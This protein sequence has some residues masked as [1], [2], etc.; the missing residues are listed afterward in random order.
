M[1]A[2]SGPASA[3]KK[4]TEMQ[5]KDSASRCDSGSRRNK[6]GSMLVLTLLLGGL[7]IFICIVAFCFFLLLS[8]NKKGRAKA[9]ETAV[10]FAKILNEDDRVGQLNH[11]VAR[12][13]ELVYLSR[14]CEQQAA[15]AKLEN[16][17]PLAHFLLDESRSG[18]VL[19][20]GERK[21]QIEVSKKAL[22]YAADHYNVH[23]VDVP[24]FKLPFWHTWDAEVS[25]IQLG[26]AADVESNVLN[27]ET[28]PDL[29]AYDEHEK[30][31]QKGSDLYRGNINARLPAP[32]N[33]LDFKLASLPAS[34][35]G[36]TSPARLIKVTSFKPAG[37]MFQ[38]S[39]FA[40]CKYD[41]IPT[42]L[43]LTELIWITAATQN[44]QQFRVD[45]FA[46]TSGA[47][48]PPNDHPK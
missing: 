36:T 34:V 18:A 33:D 10:G 11:V 27:T 40:E 38:N 15:M 21:N 23:T 3:E 5:L 13:R 30:Y 31:F 28:Y 8:E 7:L 42:A 26:S 29:R 4:E 35:Q 14:Q 45:A 46:S 12:S 9:E 24:V 17:E 2:G 20:E 32:D 43:S 16:W 37:T 47:L 1:P 44:E 22:H 19:V 39:K 25:E 41:Q 48:P 6:H